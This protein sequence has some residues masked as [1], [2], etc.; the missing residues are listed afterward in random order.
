M[1]EIVLDQNDS[2]QLKAIE[3]HNFRNYDYLELQ[4]ISNLSIFVGKN[5]VGKTSILEAIQLVTA[6]KSFRATNASQLVKWGAK[7][8]RVKAL[9]NNSKRNLELQMDVEDNKRKYF[10]NGKSKQIRDLKGLFPAVI[11]CPDDL[12][13]VKGSN[14]QRRTS[15]DNLGVQL[16]KNFYSVRNDYQK[17][18]K[19]KNQALKEEFE[20]PLLESIN[21]V[22]AKVG[23]QFFI[24]RQTLC[25]KL[26]PYIESYYS[27]LT[28]NS[29][30]LTIHYIPS[31]EKENAT[32]SEYNYS[33]E[34]L[35]E[36]LLKEINN[37]YAEEKARKKSVVG[38]HADELMFLLNERNAIHFA[39]QGQQR[40]I[41]L[42]Y[43]MAELQV[44]QESLS[45]LPVLLLDDVMSEL[46]EFRRQAFMD[47][48]KDTIQTF[49]TTTNM[50]YFDTHVLND[51]TLYNLPLQ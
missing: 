7:K 33:K 45:Q 21:D 4:D 37:S 23:A 9:F 17:I 43:K 18:L 51:S 6:L 28:N 12:N 20:L 1:S 2:L 47:F 25:S 44:L 14:T 26:K 46:D 39:S 32:F 15:L 36:I 35:Y 29:E 24:H 50:S 48:T 34:E 16:S 27:L 11:F 41:V 42:A 13:L 5:A 10:L 40:S 38:P 30:Q 3:L 19:Q 8:A 49:I 22:L 31:W